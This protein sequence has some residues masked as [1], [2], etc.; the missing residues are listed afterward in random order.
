MHGRKQRFKGICIPM[1]YDN[2]IPTKQLLIYHGPLD[3]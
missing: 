1:F 2:K 3:N